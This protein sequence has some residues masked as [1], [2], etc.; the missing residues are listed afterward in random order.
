MTQRQQ[1]M[2]HIFEWWCNFSIEY[3]LCIIFTKGTRMVGH[4]IVKIT[5]G[6]KVIQG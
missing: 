1:H 2:W 6:I 4:V 3:I 5:V